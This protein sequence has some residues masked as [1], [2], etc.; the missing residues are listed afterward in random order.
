VHTQMRKCHFGIADITGN[1]P[2]VLY[3]VG[4]MLGMGKLVILLKYDK[5]EADAA[6]D[7]DQRLRIHYGRYP[8]TTGH[9]LIVGLREGLKPTMEFMLES[10]RGLKEAQPAR[11]K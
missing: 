1:N 8:L 2:N 3:E 11:E 4:W 7:I 10:A 6:F 5:D 9:T